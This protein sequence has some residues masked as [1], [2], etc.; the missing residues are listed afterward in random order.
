MN[1]HVK[2]VLTIALL[3]LTL[4]GFGPVSGLTF[5]RAPSAQGTSSA[6]TSSAIPDESALAREKLQA[7]VD[8]LHSEIR[9]SSGFRGFFSTYAALLT[10]LAAIAAVAIT[11][12]GQIKEQS[13]QSD[14]EQ[15]QRGQ[16][17]EQRELESKRELA[18]RFSQLLLD[19]GSPS[20]PVQAGAV[21][22]LLGFLG[23]ED[24]GFRHQVRLAVL[25]NLKVGH[26]PAIA[27]L[28]IRTFEEAMSTG[29]E[30][31]FD[32]IE[33]DFARA[34]LFGARLAGLDLGGANLAEA[35]LA[36]A[37]LSETS[38]RDARGPGVILD[39]ATIQGIGASLFNARLP[40]AR[41]IGTRFKGAE[42][43]NAHLEGADLRNA[44]FEGARMQA[45]HLERNAD[46]RGARFDGANV[47]DTYF[48]DAIFDDTALKS[49]KRAQ[50]WERAHFSPDALVRLRAV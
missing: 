6:G 18:A 48:R 29:E 8:K 21:V 30:T 40:G 14:A 12:R 13:R 36:G 9:R 5:A 47:A 10:A 16:A 25:A 35:N 44:R 22:S 31:P 45:A 27:R 37:D 33:L 50:N 26:T 32:P 46:L 7:E 1:G 11:L 2:M 38:L 17:R 4:A 34:Q 3:T 42:L 23:R 28:L 15:T 19:L 41:C 39:D 43:V 20:E 49:L 24:G